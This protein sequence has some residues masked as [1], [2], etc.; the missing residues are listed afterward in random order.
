MYRGTK[1]YVA[2]RSRGYFEI[3][4]SDP[5][6]IPNATVGSGTGRSYYGWSDVHAF[7]GTIYTG[8]FHAEQ[9]T[10]SSNGIASSLYDPSDLSNLSAIYISTDFSNVPPYIDMGIVYAFKHNTKTYL[11]LIDSLTNYGGVL[12]DVT[13]PTSPSKVAYY[14][15][16]DAGSGSQVFGGGTTWPQCV[17]RGGYL[18]IADTLGLIVIDMSTSP[19]SFLGHFGS[20]AYCGA[21]L[22]PSGNLLVGTTSSGGEVFDIQ[23]NPAS[24][25]SLHSYPSASWGMNSSAGE[26]IIEFKPVSSTLVA[27]MTTPKASS[28]LRILDVSSD[29]GITLEG[30]LYWSSYVPSG[31]MPHGFEISNDGKWG[32]ISGGIN[33]IGIIDLSTPSSPSFDRWYTGGIGISDPYY[34]PYR[35]SLDESLVPKLTQNTT[36]IDKT[37]HVKF[38]V[39][40][41]IGAELGDH[42]THNAR[43]KASG[44]YAGILDEITTDLATGLS[45]VAVHPVRR[46][47]IARFQDSEIIYDTSD[48]WGTRE[49]YGFQYASQTVV[50]GW[51]DRFVFSINGGSSWLTSSIPTGD[52][53]S[54]SQIL[55]LLVNAFSDHG[56]TAS[57]ARGASDFLI[58]IT[59]S[60]AQEFVVYGTQPTSSLSG[61]TGDDITRSIRFLC[62]VIGMT[63]G[64]IIDYSGS[65]TTTVIIGG[66][67]IWYFDNEELGELA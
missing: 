50:S 20:G 1:L 67:S 5:T 6:N 3:D 57:V 49:N 35:M 28:T 12:I 25:V 31:S 58:T 48:D 11:M 43:G 45:S 8:A 2:W 9:I 37:N 36:I 17:Y 56:I 40:G 26:H 15:G 38:D 44:E 10:T 30:S 65:P 27:C 63:P 4:I 66:P 61:A 60:I 7:E 53:S 22:L 19:P 14:R 64:T 62:C 41:A 55:N 21:I 32:F 46:R 39:W 42:V 16:S 33:G 47:H 59:F 29:T 23:T 13:T 51:N 18:Y 54:E 52:Y 24:P 34:L